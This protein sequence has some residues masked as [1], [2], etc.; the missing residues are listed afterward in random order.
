MMVW[1]GSLVVRG[2][3]GGGPRWLNDSPGWLNGGP[4]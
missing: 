3:L 4:G 2:L 1:R